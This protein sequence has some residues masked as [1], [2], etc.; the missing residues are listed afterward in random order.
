MA[1]THQYQATTRWVGNEGQGTSDYK[2]YSR[3][4][5]I[6]IN[7][8]SPLLCS[9]DPSFRGDPA[10]HNPEELLVASVSGCHMLWYLHLCA[11]NR[12]I[13]EEYVDSAIGEMQENADGSGQFVQI[14]LSPRVKVADETMI[15]K[16]NELHHQANSMC[17]IARSLKFP[18]HHK[19]KAF[20]TAPVNEG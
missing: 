14:T 18:V 2:G 3:N 15:E 20:V 13:V 9:S 4:H 6:N 8:K 19:P 16:A 7:G 11:V 12:V 5:D 1:H 17:F 10:R